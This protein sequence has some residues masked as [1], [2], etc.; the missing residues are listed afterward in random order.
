MKA[1]KMHMRVTRL[2][3]CNILL[4]ATY[5]N[6]SVPVKAQQL[7]ASLL[8]YSIEDGLPSNTI[9]DIQQDDYGYIWIATWNG[10]SR[11]D[12]YHFY[13]YQT[14]NGSHIPFL[15]NRISKMAID[16]RQ[17][18]WLHMYDGRVFVLNRKTDK[19]EDPLAG[20][21]GH[22]NYHT[23]A[24]LV[25]TSTG[26]IIAFYE[27]VGI[28]KM[29]LDRNGIRRQHISTG[30]YKVT[31]VTEGYQDDIWVGTDKG[32]HRIDMSSLSLEEKSKFPDEHITSIYSNGYNIFVGTET[33]KIMS[34]SYG[35]EPRVYR[36]SGQAI[37]CIYIDSRGLIWFADPRNGVSRLIPETGEEKH[38]EQV[39]PNPEYDAFGGEFHESMGVVWAMMN[40]GGYGYYNREKDEIEYFHNDPTNPWNLSNTVRAVASLDEGVIWESTNRCG[41]EKLEVLK[42]TINRTRLVVNSSSSLDNEIRALYYDSERMK[43]IIA[44]KNSQVHIIS[45]DSSRTV[46]T[47]DNQGR[48]L[49]RAYGL[50]KDRKGNYWLCSKDNGIYRISNRG[51]SYD[52]QLY[53]SNENDP[54]S[55]SSKAAYAAV[56]DKQGRL[57]VATYGGGVNVLTGYKNGKP[58]FLHYKNDIR[59][60]PTNSYLKVRSI[61]C[62][63][64]GQIW[65]GTTDGILL[66]S[67]K[68]GKVVVKP[69]ENSEEHPDRIMMSSDIVCLACDH[70]GEMWIGTNGGGLSHVIGKDSK[71]RYLFENFGSQNRLPSEEIKSITFDEN[72]NVW[73]ATDHILCS[74]NVEKRIFSSFS[75]LDGVDETLCSEGAAITLPNGHVLFGTLNGYYVIDR[76]KLT[77]SVGSMLKLRITDF[78]LNDQQQSPRLTSY[79]NYYVPDA[80]LVEL[81]KHNVAFTFRFAA[82][83]YQLQ[84]RINYQYQLEG[85]DKTWRNADATRT[86]TYSNIPTGT[87]RFKVKAFLLESPEKYDLKVIEVIVPPYFLLSSNAIWLYMVLALIMAITIM[88]WRQRQLAIICSQP[89]TEPKGNI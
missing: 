27:G 39:V 64:Q 50:T 29:R 48:S 21:D 8:H 86:A 6:W 3:I 10:L 14:G 37:T 63:K 52:V 47:R 33:G 16:V 78:F 9:T 65:A 66:L 40:H 55:L 88:L 68:N 5:A 61:A 32:V 25:A 67:I 76:K 17:N 80:R 75:N 15:H 57:W 19:I 59:K 69:L 62:D 22:E 20:I 89:L 83:N 42:N 85:Y 36:T 13:N 44:N 56:E 18:I 49:G 30:Q 81:P 51:G 2:I 11:F 60:Y 28:Y 7:Q 45:G 84:H 38:F 77:N 58:V 12:G 74:Y 54:Y 23:G 70:K 82:L 71:G 35:Q 87:Y 31:S 72:N 46:I 79:Y 1:T 4:L 24:P 53:T 41:L 26:D 43:L 73:F 34:F